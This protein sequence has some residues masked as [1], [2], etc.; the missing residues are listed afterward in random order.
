MVSIFISKVLCYT[1]LYSLEGGEFMA[2]KT[3][4]SSKKEQAEDSVQQSVKLFRS[5]KSFYKSL[6][7]TAVIKALLAEFIG[8]FIITAAFF[9][10]N[11]R[12]PIAFALI[13]TGVV[14]MFNGVS[15][16]HVN[17]AI[18]IGA[19]VTRKISGLYA[20]GYVATQVLGA[21]V[22][23]LV[24]NSL[25][26]ASGS[27]SS[28]SGSSLFHAGTL[29]DSKGWFLFFT[30]FVGTI[31]LSLGIAMALRVK[32]NRVLAAFATGLAAISALYIIIPTTVSML[33]ESSSGFTFLNPAIAIA[34]NAVTWK[35]WPIAI[36]VV[37]P[38]LGGIVG[39]ALQ[40]FM[41]PQTID[42]K[43]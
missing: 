18:T 38:I 4:V 19:W 10:M 37:A 14:I 2:A 9:G 13:L 42:E 6:K 11:G 5:A 17:P 29:V 25:A 7:R 40:A 30:E 1:D 22:A 12:D 31:V 43:E 39:F 21:T 8:A 32:K 27:A 36:Y 23:W 33:V 16:A 41:Q 3:A 15:G 28:L 26:T 20:L 35:V 24:L 34:A